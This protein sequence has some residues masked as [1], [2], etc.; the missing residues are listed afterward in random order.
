VWRIYS[1]NIPVSLLLSV[2]FP[3]GTAL[4]YFKEIKK[5][6]TV[7]LAWGILLVAIAQYALLAETGERFTDANWI[8][9]SNIAM[10]LVFLVSTATL[11]GQPKSKRFYFLSALLALHI[12]AGVYY[13]GRI[14]LGLGY[15]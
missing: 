3:L 6:P 7:L 10:Y 13:Y 14:A 15:Y 9:A 8:W 11:I 12:A 1:P 4:L 5:D 2:A